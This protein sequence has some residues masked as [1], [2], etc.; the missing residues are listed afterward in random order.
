[1]E[2]LEYVSLAHVLFMKNILFMPT[3]YVN[4]SMIVLKDHLEEEYDCDI[5]SSEYV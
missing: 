1:M 3:F 4:Y 5:N 2:H